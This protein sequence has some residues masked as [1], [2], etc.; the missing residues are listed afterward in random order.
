MEANF[1]SSKMRRAGGVETTPFPQEAVSFLA[2]PRGKRVVFHP[3]VFL[4]YLTEPPP[5]FCR[6]PENHHDT[7]RDGLFLSPLANACLNRRMF[8]NGCSNFNPSLL[9]V[10]HK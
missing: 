3:T 7:F 2:F 6:W 10:K 8:L 9:H 5:D 1:G 4:D